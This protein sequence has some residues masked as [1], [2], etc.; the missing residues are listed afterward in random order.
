VGDR[1]HPGHPLEPHADAPPSDRDLP[2][3]LAHLRAC[4]PVLASIISRVGDDLLGERRRARP[5][6]HWGVLVRAIV[7]QQVSVASADA[8]HARLLTYIGGRTPP[9]ADLLA[10]D[11]EAV[12]PAA[13]LSRAKTVYLRSL[14]EHVA[15][16]RLPLDALSELD[17]DAVRAALTAIKGIGPWSAD[18]FLI[19]HLGRP[20]VLAVGDVGIQRAMQTRYGLDAYPSPDTMRRIAEPWRPYRTAGCLLMWRSLDLTPV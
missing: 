17:D 4:D 5:T 8:I 6:D 16:G 1:K 11:P 10:A 15:D 9:P 12:R 13:G 3:A 19:F 14:A 7:A 2:A 18:I 20:D